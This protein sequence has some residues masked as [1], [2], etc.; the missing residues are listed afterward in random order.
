LPTVS[1]HLQEY[2]NP[3][4]LETPTGRPDWR[5]PARP[6]LDL[7]R[8]HRRAPEL[9]PRPPA[10]RP[11]APRSR[12]ARSRRSGLC[13]ASGHS[14]AAQCFGANGLGGEEADRLEELGRRSRVPRSLRIRLERLLR[15]RPRRTSRGRPDPGCRRAE[16]V[17]GG[18][19]LAVL[20]LRPRTAELE[21]TPPF[22]CL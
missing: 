21:G 20:T 15:R 9:I 14:T 2:H 3:S 1:N 11:R 5:E 19:V 22:P 6:T 17:N 18:K 12:P 13:P 7:A 10:R 16:N 8:C 4:R